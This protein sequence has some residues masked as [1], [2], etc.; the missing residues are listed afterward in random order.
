MPLM[1][2]ST[3][4]LETQANCVFWL[5]S[6]FDGLAETDP[7]TGATTTV[8]LAMPTLKRCADADI[9]LGAQLVWHDEPRGQGLIFSFPFE[10][11]TITRWSAATVSA[12]DHSS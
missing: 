12:P 9:L 6:I 5:Q 11:S 7:L 3:V 10:I 2:A 8:A 4:S 1:S